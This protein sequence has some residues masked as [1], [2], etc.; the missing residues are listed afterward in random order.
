MQDASGLKP[1]RYRIIIFMSSSLLLAHPSFLLL[2]LSLF[3]APFV[4]FFSLSLL[5][6]L[7]SFIDFFI[8]PSSLLIYFC[9]VLSTSGFSINNSPPH[10]LLPQFT[11]GAAIH[12]TINISK[13]IDVAI[14]GSRREL[15]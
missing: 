6:F 15:H 9:F 7:S 3:I 2:R 5:F 14:F 1:L 13:S 12:F 8:P 11:L 10:H 4:C